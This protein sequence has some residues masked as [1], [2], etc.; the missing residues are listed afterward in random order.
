M[1]FRYCGLCVAVFNVVPTLVYTGLFVES[2]NP[3]KGDITCLNNIAF[4]HTGTNILTD[5]LIMAM[6]V[7]MTWQ[8]NMPLRKKLT[9]GALLGLS[10]M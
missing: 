1:V 3:L 5:L 6:P 10:S 4:A 8:L 9:V 7:H 2:C